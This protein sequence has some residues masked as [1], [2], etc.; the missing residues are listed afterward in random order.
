M[1]TEPQGLH[2]DELPD[3]LTVDELRTWLRIGTKKAYSL[4]N[5]PGFPCLHCYGS[6][7]IFPKAEVKEWLTREAKQ[8]RLS[9]KLRAVSG[10]VDSHA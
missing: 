2:F 3:Y 7:K 9:S 4:A 6:K 8:G 10:G 1:A 5:T